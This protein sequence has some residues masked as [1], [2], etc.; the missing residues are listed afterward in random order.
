MTNVNLGKIKGNIKSQACRGKLGVGVYAHIWFMFVNLCDFTQ[1]FEKNWL[2]LVKSQ[3]FER[4][5]EYL[6]S[7]KKINSIFNSN[8]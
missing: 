8:R 5:I 6:K 7:E 4:M 3:F 2:G 1:N